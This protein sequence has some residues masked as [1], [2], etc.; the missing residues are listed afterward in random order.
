MA[1]LHASSILPSRRSWAPPRRQDTHSGRQGMPGMCVR[2]GL[3]GGVTRFFGGGP[4]EEEGSP[5]VK[6]SSSTSEDVRRLVQQFDTSD[7][8]PRL[9]LSHEE[10]QLRISALLSGADADAS[11]KAK[12]ASAVLEQLADAGGG[13]ANRL[14]LAAAQDELRWSQAYTSTLDTNQARAEALV[15]P[16]AAC[17]VSPGGRCVAISG[18]APSRSR[19]PLTPVSCALRTARSGVSRRRTCRA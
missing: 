5:A 16:V 19:V 12:S 15:R 6:L 11:R 3:F 4:K 17:C 13:S 18:H 9:S 1:A 14:A 2:A 7:S 10:V 8:V